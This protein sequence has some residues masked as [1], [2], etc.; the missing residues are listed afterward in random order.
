V[1]SA[2]GSTAEIVRDYETGRLFRAGEPADLAA[3]IEWALT[4]PADLAAMGR[5]ARREY[6]VKYTAERN[7][8][9]LSQIYA[10]ARS[11]AN[12]M[13]RPS[14]RVAFQQPNASQT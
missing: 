14:A 2:L 6:E 10:S 13:A 8:A 7:Y 4:H 12:T 9:L 1:A 5:C 3:K 11:E